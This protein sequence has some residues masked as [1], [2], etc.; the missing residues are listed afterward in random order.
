MLEK[1]KKLFLKTLKE[2]A[3]HQNELANCSKKIAELLI[4]VDSELISL[5]HEENGRLR[6]DYAKEIYLAMKKIAED[7][8]IENELICRVHYKKLLE[9]SKADV[10]AITLGY[11]IRRSFSLDVRRD[12]AGNSV[13]FNQ[14]D[15]DRIKE[16][17]IKAGHEV[18]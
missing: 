11:L 2:M 9:I 14:E 8:L 12:S 18:E 6:E 4:D 16:L 13:F 15:L 3:Y 7:E 10:S 17:L 5:K 1:N